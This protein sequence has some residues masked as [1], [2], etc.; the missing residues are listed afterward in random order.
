[1]NSQNKKNTKNQEIKQL[2]LDRLKVLS[3]GTIISIGS[4]GDFTRDQMIENVEDSTEIGELFTEMQ[5]EWLRSFQKLA[6]AQ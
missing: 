5:I 1:M 6:T 2:V 3:P 4:E